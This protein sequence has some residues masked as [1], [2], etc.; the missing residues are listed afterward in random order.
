MNGAMVEVD[1]E[2][3]HE[4]ANA[5]LFYD[6]EQEV[7]LPQSHIAYREDRHDGTCLLEIPEWLALEK[8]LL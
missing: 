1:G 6:G 2:I 7:W 5:V 4:T 8:G 3:R